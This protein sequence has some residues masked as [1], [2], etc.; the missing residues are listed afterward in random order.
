MKT[1]SIFKLFANLASAF[2]LSI[3]LFGT[4]ETTFFPEINTLQ[5]SAIAVGITLLTQIVFVSFGFRSV[6]G[7]VFFVLQTEVWSKDISD[8]LYMGNEFMNYA[9]DHSM[10]VN[11]KTVHIPQAGAKPN[12]EQN[13]AI[14][15][16]AI[17][18]RTDTD[19]TYNLA[20]YTTDPILI[21]NLEELQVSYPKRQ[22]ILM[23][24]M[25]SLQFVVSTQTLYAWAPSG[26]TRWVQT[27]GSTSTL[28]L[29]HTTATGSRKMTTIADITALKSILDKDLVPQTGRIL[30]VP[31]YMYN[32]DLLNISGIVQAYQFGQ[33]VA[34][35]GVVARLM[36]FDIMI[37]AEV[38]VYDSNEVIKAINGDGTLTS[39][40]TTDQGAALAFHPKYVC[41][42][43]GA[44]IPY[45]EENSPIYYGSILSAEV[46]HGASKLYTTQKGVVALI[47]GT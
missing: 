5:V 45:Y 37:R 4:L 13:R 18:Q 29:P 14:L 20:N 33:A 12:T 46:N 30:L 2:L 25:A 1:K 21:Q 38:L 9:T 7:Y 8:N 34:P 43:L 23:N 42:A 40:A 24:M 41:H 32:V 39:P 19:L 28:N 26:A 36:G 6:K 17:T 27:S 16:A 11:H 35:N 15:P 10:W 22:S 47:Q 44:I 31:E 3:V